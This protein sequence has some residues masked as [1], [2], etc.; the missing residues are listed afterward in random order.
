MGLAASVCA[1]EPKRV[2]DFKAE[3]SKLPPLELPANAA[4]AVRNA[5]AKERESVAIGAVK[6]AVEV[7]PTVC[8]AVV[9]SIART[10]PEV[11]PAAAATGARLQPKL[12]PAI[13]KAAA[14]AAPAQAGQIA[15]AVCRALPG[16]YRSVALAVAQAVPSASSDI[17]S[18][19][20]A[21]IPALKP[22]L[23]EAV[24]A[25]HSKGELNVATVLA[26]SDR[27]LAASGGLSAA[28][29]ELS[30]GSPPPPVIG[31]PYVPLGTNTIPREIS[32]GTSGEV[33][34]GNRYSSP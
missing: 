5:D 28:S 26:E 29:L 8:A 20:S 3:F 24:T 31:P 1:N 18:G 32:P 22:Y 16:Q 17:L 23:S 6:S 27:R 25:S 33:P 2:Y 15:S 4:K 9:T 21:A 13:A 30:A 19:L 12:A 11:A 10:S 14:A 7:N 34:P